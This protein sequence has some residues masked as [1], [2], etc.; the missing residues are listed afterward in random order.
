M[1]RVELFVSGCYIC[2]GLKLVSTQNPKQIQDDSGAL[3][4]RRLPWTRVDVFPL[5][6]RP[7]WVAY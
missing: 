3:V 1:A 6:R 2:L 5:I 7:F 4:V